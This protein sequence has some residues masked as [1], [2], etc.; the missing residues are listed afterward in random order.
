MVNSFLTLI[1]GLFYNIYM[2]INLPSVIAREKIVYYDYK[3]HVIV[4]FL[5]K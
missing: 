1:F 3:M 2:Y 5:R 4:L